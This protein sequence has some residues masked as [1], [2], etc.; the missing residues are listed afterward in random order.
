V[1]AIIQRTFTGAARERAVAFYSLILSAGVFAGQA[2]GG[3][4][5]SLDI[6]GLGWRP[7]FLVNIPIGLVALALARRALP[8]LEPSGAEGYDVAGMGLLAGAMLCVLVPLVFGRDL[9]WPWWT[10]LVLAIGLA[11]LVA[12]A[13]YERRVQ[14]HGGPMLLDLDVV[15]NPGVAAAGIAMCTAMG[16]YAALVFALTLRLQ[17][18]LGFSPLRSGATIACYA[19]GF[20][21]SSLLWRR[22]CARTGVAYTVYGYGGFA[23]CSLALAGLLRNG[24][25]WYAIAVL[26]LAGWC[27]AVTFAPLFNHMLGRVDQRHAAEVSGLFSTLTLLAGAVATA[28]VGGI[29]LAAPSSASGITR[30]TLVIAAAV[31]A[32]GLAAAYALNASAARRVEQLAPG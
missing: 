9:A 25:A 24:L 26:V 30:V 29:Y 18:G 14:R 2:L 6:A 8:R 7:L 5:V 11:G 16:A 13:R 15:Q 1:L 19:A 23:A 31:A 32:A 12:F 21:A 28:G 22:I 3:A 20:G 17:Q 4:L 10:W 27:H